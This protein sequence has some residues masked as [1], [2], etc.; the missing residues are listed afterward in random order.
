MIL[1][2]QYK[3]TSGPCSFRSSPSC[4]L[5]WC[6]WWF[7]CARALEASSLFAYSWAFVMA[8]SSPSWLPLH[9][10][11]WAQCRLH[12]PLVT[13]W[14][15]WLCLWLLD[16]PL[17][18]RMIFQG[19]CERRNPIFP[20]LKISWTSLREVSFLFFISFLS[21]FIRVHKIIYNYWW[22]NIDSF[23]GM[24]FSWLYICF[25]VFFLH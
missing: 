17:Q 1:F 6:L 25:S 9:L 11:W 8:S 12:K 16:P 10:S 23:W 3:I 7:P 20:E 18:V 2:S 24:G 13:S 5:V 14:A 4:F 19:R 15:W 21:S 22:K